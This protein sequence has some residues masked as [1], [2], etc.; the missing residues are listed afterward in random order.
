MA[1][2][3]DEL[4]IHIAEYQALR[5]EAMERIKGI[6]FLFAYI[7][8]ALATSLVVLP[9]FIKTNNAP[10]PHQNTRTIAARTSNATIDT[11]AK[12]RASV[13][14][15][16]SKSPSDTQL[17]NY[18]TLILLLAP[19]L[20]F[21]LAIYMFIQLRY[22]RIIAFY[23]EHILVS[24][25][26]QLVGNKAVFQFEKFLSRKRR[27]ISVRLGGSSSLWA[28]WGLASI[29][30]YFSLSIGV[31]NAS[32]SNFIFKWNGVP[33]DILLRPL[34]FFDM[35]ILIIAPISIIIYVV[36]PAIGSKI[37]KKRVDRYYEGFAKRQLD[38]L[39]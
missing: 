14:N 29:A 13:R 27:L 6:N 18:Q 38:R 15:T 23:L 34:A 1:R 3:S 26:Q 24:S 32:R 4:G 31:S 22:I 8:L 39:I 10:T 35:L 19:L 2:T 21:L 36:S 16:P 37:S 28:L 11:A 12:H 20:L 5:Q 17:K 7:I 25:V 30:Y 9:I 33:K